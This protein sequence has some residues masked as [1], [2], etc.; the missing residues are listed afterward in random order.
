MENKSMGILD[1]EPGYMRRLAEYIS[2]KEGCRIRVFT[3]NSEEDV[4]AHL[5]K[6]NLDILLVGQSMAGADIQNWEK[7]GQLVLL[8]ENS[9]ETDAD[10]TS[11][12]KFQAAD[13]VFREVMTC[14]TK[15]N[16]KMTKKMP[17]GKKGQITGIY[18]P[19]KRC[20]KTIFS[21][22][23]ASV[24]AEQCRSLF[25]SL[26]EF[27]MLEEL[28]QKENE[29]DLAD[30]MFL[31]R[32]NPEEGFWQTGMFGRIHGLEYIPP[33]TFPWD[34]RQIR[35]EE[36]AELIRWAAGRGGYERVILDIGEGGDSP[37]ELLDVCEK[38]YMPELDD[39]ISAE[40]IDSFEKYMDKSGN[41]QL[42][43][44]II[45]IQLPQ[46]RLEAETAGIESL[47]WSPMEAF[48]REMTGAG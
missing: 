40:K 24:Y 17:A 38:I 33:V 30:I 13:G 47:L 25:I 37:L 8:N 45:K 10:R 48:V 14:Y 44:K 26:D 1:R 2:S 28:R 5:E 31:Y 27:C 19:V 15:E 41:Q 36:L 29:K 32:Q 46:I 16:G 20:G 11:V 39:P 34:L 42:L 3:F 21:F 22:V 35:T 12:Y 6:N 9:R 7:I 43:E 18:S 23:L 4:A